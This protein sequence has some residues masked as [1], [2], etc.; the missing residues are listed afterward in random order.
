MGGRIPSS[1]DGFLKNLRPPIL[2]SEYLGL[3]NVRLYVRSIDRNLLTTLFI[4]CV[5][6]RD[7]SDWRIF[8]SICADPESTV[9]SLNDKIGPMYVFQDG[10]SVFFEHSP[11]SIIFATA[12]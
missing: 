9:S 11:R 2:L 6:S 5:A 10:V 8:P 7:I 4:A 12:H 1:Y 3:S